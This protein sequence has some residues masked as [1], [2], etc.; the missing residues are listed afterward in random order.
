MIHT[1]TMNKEQK[2]MKEMKLNQKIYLTNQEDR[3]RRNAQES[4]GTNRK[5]Q[6]KRLKC[7]YV[8]VNVNGMSLVRKKG[9]SE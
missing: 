2:V 4:K 5:Y 8:I 6:G 9:F 7:D 1:T 3:K